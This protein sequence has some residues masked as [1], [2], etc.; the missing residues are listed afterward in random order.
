MQQ[1]VL[2]FPMAFSNDFLVPPPPFLEVIRFTVY[3]MWLCGTMRSNFLPKKKKKA[4]YLVLAHFPPIISI[5]LTKPVRK[6]AIS[7][8][9]KLKFSWDIFTFILKIY[10]TVH[11]SVTYLKPEIIRLNRILSQVNGNAFGHKLYYLQS[12]YDL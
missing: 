7:F 8:S 10:Y 2:H 3:C 1:S 11:V 6:R 5:S 9:W 12:K 4:L